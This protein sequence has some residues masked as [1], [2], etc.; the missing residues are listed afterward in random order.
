MAQLEQL[1]REQLV[2][3]WGSVIVPMRDVSCAS[4]AGGGGATTTATATA[5][6]TSGRRRYDIFV[7]YDR[8]KYILRCTGGVIGSFSSVGNKGLH[9]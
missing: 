1:E 8:R 5:T 6:A 4:S 2:R 9:I 3:L 7:S